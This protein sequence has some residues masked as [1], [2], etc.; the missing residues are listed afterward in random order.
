MKIC[1]ECKGKGYYEKIISQY[2]ELEEE[3]RIE[4]ESC[5]LC[6]GEKE[7]DNLRHAVYKARGGPSEKYMKGYA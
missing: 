2:W 1:P 7:I 6:N 5:L 3:V 4:R